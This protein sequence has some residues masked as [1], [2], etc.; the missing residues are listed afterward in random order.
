[1]YYKLNRK[2]VKV[3]IEITMA[4]KMQQEINEI[5]KSDFNT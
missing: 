3:K 4:L 5:I 1:M 2:T